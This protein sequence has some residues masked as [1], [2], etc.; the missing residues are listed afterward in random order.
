MG[1]ARWSGRYRRIESKKAFGRAGTAPRERRSGMTM[2]SV[3]GRPAGGRT[4]LVALLACVVFA[5]GAAVA[6]G[7]GETTGAAAPTAGPPETVTFPSHVGEVLFPHAM[8]VEDL[9]I[10]CTDCHHPVTA[11]KLDTPHPE[12]F[13]GCS[14]R[15]D[16]CHGRATSE[17]ADHRCSTCHPATV[18]AAH[19]A[20]PSTKV[21]LHRTCFT[22]HEVGTGPDASA[23]CE[24]CHSGP[25]ASW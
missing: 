13:E 16:T 4:V 3:R 11:P 25:K 15:C 6:V 20:I 18:D 14:V 24:N 21:A 5:V 10:D 1:S 2:R 7:G 17:P 19:D 12:T 8:H 22:C 9:G 23:S